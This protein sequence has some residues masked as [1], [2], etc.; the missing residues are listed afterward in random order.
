MAVTRI[1]SRRFPLSSL[2]S[3]NE[4][5]GGPGAGLGCCDVSHFET[6]TLWLFNIAMENGLFIDGLPGFTYLKWWFSMAMLNNQMVQ[7]L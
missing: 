5:S 1:V 6:P 7:W 2:R 4:K 3:D